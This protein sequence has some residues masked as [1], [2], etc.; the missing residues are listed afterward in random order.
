MWQT[1][2]NSCEFGG[3]SI[4]RWGSSNNYK[5]TP[6]NSPAS[7]T[8]AYNPSQGVDTHYVKLLMR[9]FRAVMGYR[10]IVLTADLWF[11][12][13]DV[14]PTSGVK[15]VRVHSY[16]KPYPD[17]DDCDYQYKDITATTTWYGGGYAAQ[18]GFDI[19]SNYI[20][21]ASCDTST[22]FGSFYGEPFSITDYFQT[23]LLNND[24]L[25]MEFF[26]ITHSDVVF[27]GCPTYAAA[28]PTLNVF[29]FFPVEMFPT[30]E[31]GSTIDMTRLLNTDNEPINLGAYQK[32]QTGTAQKFW[33]KNFSGDTIAHIEVY[34]DY[35]EWST[36]VA[37]SGN[38]GS[39]A[40]GYVTVYE[41]CV[42]QRWEVKFSS[43]TAFE[44]KA[45]AYLDNIESLHPSYD[46]DSNW[47]GLTSADWDSPGGNV[48]IPSAAWSGTPSTGDLFVFYTRG[49]TTD[50]TWPADSNDQVEICGDSGGSPDGD[51]RP[52]TGR[53]TE[54]TASVTID[55]ASKT[56]SVKRIVTT[57][58]PNGT[59]I[60]IANQDTIDK[61]QITGTTA[62][63]ITIGSLSITNNTYASGAIVAT[64]LP[65]RSLAPT[66]WAQLNADSGASETY[67]KRV[68]IEDAD[69]QNFTGGQNVFLQNNS[70][71][72]ITEEGQINSITSTYIELVSDMTNDYVAGDI[73][74]QVGT[75]E[76]AFHMRVVA[77]SATDEELKE[78][79]LN[80]IA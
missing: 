62:T 42:S 12:Q 36:P 66:P 71:P 35:P 55:A 32:N 26:Q 41:A 48:T 27:M 40:L 78:F 46:A 73:C 11:R 29:Y 57:D 60:F 33:L 37:D 23:Q 51:W 50:T 74:V 7:L 69:Q 53:R 39:G 9:R 14:S 79:R 67:P 56:V 13:S 24:D 61:G 75:G 2:W 25:H 6:E 16:I 63:S 10:A 45:T 18:Y 22:A 30:I 52:I 8:L 54:S 68:Y 20:A 28:E 5:T 17:L 44:V 19:T 64:T 77:D 38:G 15:D 70:D 49:N 43:S 47:Q 21:K 80:V 72:T 59:E 65:F 3:R 4:T 34:D 76:A 31:G 1:E 58:W